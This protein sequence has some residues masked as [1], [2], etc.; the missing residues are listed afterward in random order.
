MMAAPSPAAIA[1]EM[2]R[3]TIAISAVAGPASAPATALTVRS[4]AAIPPVPHVSAVFV[5]LFQVRFPG[6]ARAR[7]AGSGSWAESGGWL[8]IS[9][10][11]AARSAYV[12]AASAWPTRASSSSSVRRPLDRG[13]RR[14]GSALARGIASRPA[15]QS[16]ALAAR[17]C[18]ARAG[19]PRAICRECFRGNV[20]S[21]RRECVHAARRPSRT[22]RPARAL[23]QGTEAAP[24]VAT[25]QVTARSGC[26][27][28]SWGR[29]PG[30]N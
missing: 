2:V 6:N 18:R 24:K 12:R 7:A 23:R 10:V 13:P 22:G 3:N 16:L 8:G 20:R 29:C 17:H 9:A 27:R 15:C 21:C 25:A 28:G 4:T 19:T 5:D 30:S 14:F 11:R 1:A 26:L